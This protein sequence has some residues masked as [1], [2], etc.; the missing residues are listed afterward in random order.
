MSKGNNKMKKGFT[1]IEMMIVVA[2]IA[3]L[4]GVAIPQYGKYVRK[5]E[6]VEG[7]RIMKQIV[8]AELLYDST[9]NGFTDIADNAAALST[10]DVTVPVAKFANYKVDK[11]TSGNGGGFMVSSTISTASTPTYDPDEAVFMVYPKRASSGT[12]N[13]S[14][15]ITDYV[16]VATSSTAPACK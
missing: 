5:S 10:L 8:D 2:I 11:C 6:T 4:A 16:N 9:H 13:G 3:I 14:T 12:F 15:Y 7:I 1:L